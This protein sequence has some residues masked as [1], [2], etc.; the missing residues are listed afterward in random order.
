MFQP[1]K[2]KFVSF[3]VTQSGHGEKKNHLTP[4][5]YST[6][7]IRSLGWKDPMCALAVPSWA[8]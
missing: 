2:F 6:E 4:F 8:C 5:T 1:L 3:I 7:H